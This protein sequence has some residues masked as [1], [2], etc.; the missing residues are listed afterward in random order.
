MAPAPGG[1]SRRVALQVVGQTGASSLSP[2]R[3][4]LLKRPTR[5]AGN[6]V[7]VPAGAWWLPASTSRR[8]G[9]LHV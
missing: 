7:D 3:F 5:M 6:P 1:P 9:I 2:N 4:N 8:D